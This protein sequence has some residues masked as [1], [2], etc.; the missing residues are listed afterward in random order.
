LPSEADQLLTLNFD[1]ESGLDHWQDF[2]AER[3]P[4]QPLES[5]KSQDVYAR[6]RILCAIEKGKQTLPAAAVVPLTKDP[7]VL[8]RRAALRALGVL[9]EPATIPAIEAALLDSENSVR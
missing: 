4:A 7:D 6:R 3:I 9:K 2:Y 8:V 1:I 5:L